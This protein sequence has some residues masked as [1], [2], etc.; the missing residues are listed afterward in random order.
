MVLDVRGNVGTRLEK[1]DRGDF[2][3]LVLAA[4]GVLR[5]GFE[6]RI[7]EFLTTDVML[8]AIGQGALGIECREED[9]AT[10]ELIAPLCHEE[11]YQCV[12]AERALSR[13]MYGDCHVPIAGHAV[14]RNGELTLDALV[15]R[16]DGSEVVRMTTSGP[17]ASAEVLGD[18]LGRE[19]LGAGG[20]AIL[21]ASRN[22]G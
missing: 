17:A 1:L 10:R 18:A 7:R 4:A 6:K 12:L 5:L 15:G 2:D 3:A 9:A 20:D 22:D 19:I 16:L 8:P 11:T 13:R 14:I 21:K